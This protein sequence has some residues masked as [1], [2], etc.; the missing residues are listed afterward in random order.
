MVPEA[1]QHFR[2]IF[3]QSPSS[4]GSR[5]KTLGSHLSSCS[6]VIQDENERTTTPAEGDKQGRCEHRGQQRRQSKRSS[7]SNTSS[8]SLYSMDG[9]FASSPTSAILGD[10]NPPFIITN[11]SKHQLATNSKQQYLSTNQQAISWN[12]SSGRQ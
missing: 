10:E 6:F 5:L 2:A 9:W 12:G 8:K 3:A 7:T 11:D 1:T 4:V